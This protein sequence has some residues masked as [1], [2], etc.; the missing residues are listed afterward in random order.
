MAKIHDKMI[1]IGTPFYYTD[2]YRRMIE[3]HR[4]YF[5][6]QA[7]HDPKVVNDKLA[8]KYEGN[9]YGLLTELRYKRQYFWA[10]MRINGFMRPEDYKSEST[11]LVPSLKEI[12]KQVQILTVKKYAF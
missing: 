10:I 11:I 7:E 9:F 4:L 5:R 6:K 2:Q 3:E 1:T 12:D 8:Y